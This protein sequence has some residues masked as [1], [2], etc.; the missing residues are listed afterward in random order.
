MQD[1][2]L[3]SIYKMMVKIRQAEEG[4]AEKYSEQKMRC[5]THLCIGQEAVSAAVGL[6][7]KKTDYAVSTHRSHGHYLGKGGNLNK[8]IAEIYGKETG[9]S[10]GYGGSMHLVDKSSGF[11]GSTAIVGNSIPV[12]IG[13]AMGLKL[14]KSKSISVIFLG[15]GAIEE[16][17]FAESVNFAAQQKIPV[18]FICENNLYSVYSPLK[19]RQPKGRKNYKM[20]EAMGVKSIS[21]DGND[22]EKV[23]NLANSSIN[24]IKNNMGPMFLEFSTYRWLEHCGPNYDN[25]LSY[26]SQ[27][28]FEKWKKLDPLKKLE[29]KLLDENII[30]LDKVNS[31][32][33]ETS[34]LVSNA[35]KFAENSNFPKPEKLYQNIYMDQN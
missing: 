22:A 33:K 17:V 3:I 5:P 13:L 21:C 8:M 14:E 26:R 12:G 32:K 29:Q 10:K 19:A 4:I 9:C 27:D 11:M 28:E 23:F 16:G 15:E 31:I 25:H 34:L 1:N 18:L 6:A 7:L 24:K 35:F 2:T 20:V 30:N